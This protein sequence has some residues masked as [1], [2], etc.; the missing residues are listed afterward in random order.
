MRDHG[1]RTLRQPAFV[2]DAAEI[3]EGL[4]RLEQM[5]FARK[6]FG[7]FSVK[8]AGTMSANGTYAP[9]QLENYGNGPS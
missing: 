6:H 2:D 5:A 3:T 1:R 4:E 8:G 9:V 7:G